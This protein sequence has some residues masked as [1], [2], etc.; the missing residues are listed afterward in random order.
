MSEAV[1]MGERQ[2]RENL[3]YHRPERRT[4]GG[5]EARGLE[6]REHTTRAACQGSGTGVKTRWL[7]KALSEGTP[8][9]LR[10][11][12]RR[13]AKVEIERNPK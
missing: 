11:H 9:W 10:S 7:A 4:P 13:G 12:K 6:Q 5:D 8:I 1:E 3:N 2:D